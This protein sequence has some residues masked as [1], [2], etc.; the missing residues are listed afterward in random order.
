MKRL[1]LAV[2]G[3]LGAI[4]GLAVIQS[5][6]G[7]PPGYKILFGGTIE[8][9][10]ALS[11]LLL[12]INRKKIKRLAARRVTRTA[13]ALAALCFVFI[14]FYITLF[15][16]CV[17]G[18]Q[19]GTAYYPLWTGGKAADMVARAGSRRAAIERYGIDAVVQAIDEMPGGAVELT[20]VVLLFVYQGIFTT[21]SL[22]FGL[23]SF[24]E[25]KQLVE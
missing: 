25:G 2:T 6:I 15:S 19:R 22:M 13:I 23:V 8:T 4:P 21:L 20:T 5:G 17:V 7:S 12:W 10:G 9:F 16:L 14:A 18:H 3:L 11:L 1:L 24:Y